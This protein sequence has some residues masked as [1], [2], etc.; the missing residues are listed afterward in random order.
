MNVHEQAIW[1]KKDVMLLDKKCVIL[2]V[3]HLRRMALFIP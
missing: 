2:Y 3:S 1:L